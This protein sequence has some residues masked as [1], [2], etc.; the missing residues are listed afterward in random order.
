M[1]MKQHKR[2]QIT[3]LLLLMGLSLQSCLGIGDS[4]NGFQTKTT[5]G[6]QIG[7]NQTDQAIFQGKIYFTLNR[8]LNVLDGK[9]EI[10]DLTRRL[11]VRDPT[12]SPDGKWVAFI[13]R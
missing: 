2:W 1:A 5:G 4:N 8:S 11:D 9:H 7:V 10:K 13:I 3:L 12:V 6:T